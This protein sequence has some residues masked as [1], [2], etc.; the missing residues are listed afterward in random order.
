MKY[1]EVIDRIK[2]FK[3]DVEFGKISFD[4]DDPFAIIEDRGLES[5]R[6]PAFKEEV[7]ALAWIGVPEAGA[8]CV[9]TYTMYI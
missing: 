1:N 8:M 9:Y 7:D 2:K 4:Q 6:V 3:I 5:G